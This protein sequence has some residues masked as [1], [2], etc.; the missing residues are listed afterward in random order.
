MNN[1]ELYVNKKFDILKVIKM[2][3][4]RKCW[5][6]TYTLY[7]TPAHEVL[8]VM[9]SY[10]FENQYATFTLKI[11]EKLGNGYDNTTLDIYTNREDYTVEFI[12]KLLLKRIIRLLADYRESI[13]RR[14]AGNNYPYTA[15]WE[16]SEEEWIE[17]FGLEEKVN[18]IDNLNF[19]N[20]EKETLIETL[21][22]K[23]LD[24]Y[25]HEHCYVPRDKYVEKALDS[26]R[27]KPILD[28]IKEIEEELDVL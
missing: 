22:D 1:I 7:S 2:V 20:D 19:D 14:E 12:N 21:L 23:N 13:F 3:L 16:K 9:K 6:E 24:D 15:L 25:N 26:D 8:A 5:G 27:E 4:K 18:E 10:D 17:Q 28:L 11:N